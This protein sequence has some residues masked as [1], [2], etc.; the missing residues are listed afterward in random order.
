MQIKMF[1]IV[2]CIKKEARKKTKHKQWADNTKEEEKN[3]RG[4]YHDDADWWVSVEFIISFVD[5]AVLIAVLEDSCWSARSCHRWRLL[6]E[7]KE[8]SVFFVNRG[9]SWFT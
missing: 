1:I 2:L 6:L 3:S 7:K 9:F 4:T 8:I 5:I